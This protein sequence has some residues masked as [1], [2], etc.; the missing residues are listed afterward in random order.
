MQDIAN[1][2]RRQL[3]GLN[4]VR[5]ANDLHGA[6]LASQSARDGAAGIL[7]GRIAIEHQHDLAKALSEDTLGRFVKARPHQR[8]YRTN[9]GLVDP[10]AVEK[11]LDNHD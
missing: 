9:T 1:R 2:L 6:M 3:V 5:Q 7:P 8:H 4:R 11:A 10:E